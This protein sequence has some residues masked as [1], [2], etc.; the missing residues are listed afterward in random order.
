MTSETPHLDNRAAERA[1]SRADAIGERGVAVGGADSNGELQT[2]NRSLRDLVI[3]AGLAVLDRDG[4]SLGARSLGYTRVFDHLEREH[5][6]KV[7]RAS[8]HERIWPS[9]N[10]YRRDVVAEAIAHLPT[11]LF[12][13]RDDEVRAWVIDM[14]ARGLDASERV[15][16]F[17]RHLGPLVFSMISEMPAYRDIQK[18]KAMAAPLNDPLT[19]EALRGP[20]RDRVAAILAT[21]RYRM[22]ALTAGLG[23]QPKPALGLDDVEVHELLSVL[24]MN[25]LLG[26]FLDVNSGSDEI[27]RP[28]AFLGRPSTGQAPWTM[29][30]IGIKAAIDQLY[31]DAGNGPPKVA[32]PP[33]PDLVPPLRISAGDRTRRRRREELRELV[34]AAGVEVLL[35]ERMDLRPESLSYASVFAHLREEHGLTVYRSS[36]HNRVWAS[37]DDYLLDVLTRGIHS[38]PNPNLLAVADLIRPVLEGLSA[39]TVSRHQAALDILRIVTAAEIER[40]LTSIDYLRRQAIKAALL[41]EPGSDVMTS[42]RQAIHTTQLQRAGR[43]AVAIRDHVLA[44]GFEVR[45]ELGI[46]VEEA[47]R[48]L[49]VVALTSAGGA[50][51]DQSAGVQAVARAYPIQREGGGADGWLAPSVAMWA[52]FDL[53][54]QEAGATPDIRGT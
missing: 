44:L 29:L 41:T 30:A 28:V 51:F 42:L 13:T 34:L 3:E 18:A 54:F 20:I 16:E 43:H 25:L 40:S 2:A 19:T 1:G 27:M 26:A 9:H 6:I 39:G 49:V 53:L 32:D 36:V 5:G 22:A 11:N 37:H 46:G 45:P 12:A 15:A 14:W 35:R 4:L 8:V 21:V 31:E 17:S 10:D 48:I 47:L 50:I 24:F 38:D 52:C 23:L 7:T 33:P